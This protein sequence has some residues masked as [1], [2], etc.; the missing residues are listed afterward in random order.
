MAAREKANCVV[1]YTNGDDTM[2]RP[3]VRTRRYGWLIMLLITA[4]Y[5]PR[6]APSTPP[7]TPDI[8]TEYLQAAAGHIATGEYTAAETA[9]RE[10]IQS[11]PENPQPI[12]D[13]ARLYLLWRRPQEGL[14]ALDEALRCGASA[15]D[16]AILRLELL[17]IAGNWSQV[18]IEATERLHTYPN[19]GEALGLLTEAYLQDY[20]CVAATTISQRWH[21]AVPDDRDATLTWNLLASDASQLCETDARL[22]ETTFCTQ[23]T[24][25]TNSDMDLAAAL[26]R[27]GNWPL[28]ACVLTRAAASNDDGSTFTAEMHTWLGEALTRLGR[29]EEAQTHLIAATTLAPEAPLGWLLLG[30]YYLSQQDT[31]AARES[32][33]RARDLDPHNPAPYLALAEATAQAGR[34][35]EVDVWISAALDN[36]PTDADIAKAA[37]RFYLERHLIHAEYP[38]RAIQ[39]ATQ[40]APDDGEAQML[41]GQFRLMAGDDAGA[42]TAL[43][44]AVKLDTALGQA[45]YLRGLALEAVGK[46]TEAQQALVRAA[47]LGYWP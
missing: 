40:L 23:T 3:T 45:H 30:T 47:D 26:I 39:S 13:L 20:Q 5:T 42:L 7:V 4:I 8:T 18:T 17:A 44:A 46:Q 34:Y 2:K 11:A 24:G 6:C 12:L 31:T 22:G 9:Y 10:A 15:Q 28:A 27:N 21:E 25:E 43:D 36:A 14:S 16:N 29:P 19:D 38:F 1:E 35:D 32:L 33:L 41:L 37:A